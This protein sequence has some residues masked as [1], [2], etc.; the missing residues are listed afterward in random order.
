MK[1]RLRNNLLYCIA[2]GNPVFLDMGD[3]RYFGLPAKANATFQKLVNGNPLVAGDE[4]QLRILLSRHIIV[5]DQEAA[6]LIP[7]N[8]VLPR[9]CRDLTLQRRRT[10]I[11]ICARA[12]AAELLSARTLRRRQLCEVKQS[13]E[14]RRSLIPI[15]RSGTTDNRIGEVAEAFEWSRLIFSSKDRCLVRSLAFVSV[16]IDLRQHV[17]LVLGVTASPFSAHCW[18]QRDDCVLNDTV[19]RVRPFT[20]ILVI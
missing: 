3:D 16:C 12:V 7:K 8:A 11:T 10:T 9:V 17:S 1:Y 4:D 5:P 19:E 15:D 18:V 20:P 14:T 6:G 13:I 2:G